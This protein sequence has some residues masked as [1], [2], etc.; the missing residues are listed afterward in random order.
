MVLAIPRAPTL[1]VRVL[2]A[3]V[4]GELPSVTVKVMV[5]SPLVTGPVCNRTPAGV[6]SSPAGSGAEVSQT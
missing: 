3:V 6:R 4:G 2:L 1:S 5:L